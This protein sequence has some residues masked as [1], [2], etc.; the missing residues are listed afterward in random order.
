MSNL[1][2]LTLSESVA[3]LQSGEFSS[4]ELVRAYLQRIERLRALAGPAAAGP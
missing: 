3:G 2:D 1:T 4:Q